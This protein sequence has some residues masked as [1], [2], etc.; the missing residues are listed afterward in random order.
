MNPLTLRWLGR[1]LGWT[2]CYTLCA[3][4]TG[5]GAKSDATFLP[6][7][8]GS[9]LS[10]VSNTTN[11]NFYAGSRLL[12]QASFGPTAA[13]VAS[14][15]SLGMPAWLD[16]QMTLRP[17]LFE[18]DP[19][20]SINPMTDNS[21]YQWLSNHLFSTIL[22]N[23]DQLRWRVAWSLS[24]FLVVSQAKV[25]PYGLTRYF[26]IL[27]TDAFGNY[28]DLLRD[29]TLSST[30]GFYLDNGSNVRSGACPGCAPNENYARELMQLFTLGTYLLN[31][32]GTPK[33][34]A[35]GQRMATYD[36]SAIENM[37]RALTGWNNVYDPNAPFA[38]WARFDLKM[39][40]ND[41]NHDTNSKVLYGTNIP[42]G[43]TAATDLER[44]LDVLMAHPNI[45]PFVS[46]RLIQHL[47]T[48]NPSPA[49]MSRVS[50][51]FNNNGKGIKGD[52][53]AVIKAILTDPE[54]RAGDSPSAPNSIGKLRE[55]LLWT[56][57][58]F[59][60]LGCKFLPLSDKGYTLI[61]TSQQPLSPQTVFGFYPPDHKAPV[62]LLLAPEQ[63][64]LDTAEFAQR[65]GL[66]W[67]IG[68]N[69]VALKKAGC[70]FDELVNALDTSP[71][72][73]LSQVSQ[74]YFRGAMSP[75]MRSA[76][77]NLIRQFK[78]NGGN[79]ALVAGQTLVFLLSSPAFG[80][81]H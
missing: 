48:S 75:V 21:A 16:Q 36:Q 65:I 42:A 58:L 34:D 55:P 73:Y 50:A 35:K 62:S 26:N 51:V 40:P 64:L 60:G 29:V 67:Q 31:V 33:L 41:Y 66:G 27:L 76:G 19:L 17:T 78:S 53:A 32:D 38:N 4:L 28:R 3:I 13:T 79:T 5:C 14:V 23:S 52:L 46:L 18:D 39:V 11:V 30:M 69:S 61:Y 56:S 22:S 80:A 9:Q 10:A 77:E 37:A 57:A 49:Y 47:V 15:A 20:K 24:Q 70:H 59:R 44:V 45:A 63:K 81:M 12:E 72:L 68:N 25:Q 2:A 43:G 1:C 8:S 54:A 74:N 6:D 7:R 71:E